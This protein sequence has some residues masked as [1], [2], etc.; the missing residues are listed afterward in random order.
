MMKRF[1]ALLIAVCMV[2]GMTACGGEKSGGGG[3]TGETKATLNV[4]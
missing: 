4:A 1:L 3:N 2:A